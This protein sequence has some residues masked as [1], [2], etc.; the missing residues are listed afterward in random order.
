[1]PPS[2]SRHL[3][4]INLLIGAIL[5]VAGVT[6]GFLLTFWFLVV[7]LPITC[8]AASWVMTLTVPPRHDMH[9]IGTLTLTALFFAWLFYFI[10]HGAEPPTWYGIFVIWGIAMIQ[11]FALMSTKRLE[12]EPVD[13]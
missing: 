12:V 4:R 6:G 11:A 3:H 8:V 7:L 5:V 10:Q 1:M 2:R 9:I 13:K